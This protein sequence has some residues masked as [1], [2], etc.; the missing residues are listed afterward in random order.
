MNNQATHDLQIVAGVNE[1]TN[2]NAMRP[3]HTGEIPNEELDEIGLSNIE[4]R[5]H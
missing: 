3:M 4:F 1:V 5:R 2:M